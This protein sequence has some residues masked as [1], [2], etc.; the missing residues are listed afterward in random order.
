MATALAVGDVA[1]VHYNTSTD[2]FSFVFLRDVE[3]GT[4]V[5]F[6]D[7]GWLAAGGFRSGEDTVTYTAPSAVTA[8][9]IITLTGLNLGK[10]PVRGDL[11]SPRLRSRR[12][13]LLTRPPPARG[14]SR[15][16]PSAT[17]GSIQGHRESSL[18]TVDKLQ[19]P[20]YLC[21]EPRSWLI[22]GVRMASG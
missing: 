5:N 19:Q 18:Y 9:T 7:N 11:S 22:S 8:G 20:G 17:A 10:A 14:Y 4:T 1:V 15:A 3:A 6:T 21:A 16:P 12:A 2:A 13:R